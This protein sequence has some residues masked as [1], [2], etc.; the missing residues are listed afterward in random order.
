SVGISMA[1][2]SDI[3]GALALGGEALS[4]GPGD[5]LR[6]TLRTWTCACRDWTRGVE[7]ET[8]RAGGGTEEEDTGVRAPRGPSSDA[9]LL[10]PESCP[11]ESDGSRGTL[12]LGGEGAGVGSTACRRGFGTETS[13]RSCSPAARQRAS[14][15]RSRRR[16]LSQRS[17]WSCRSRHWSRCSA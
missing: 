13:W 7:P 14:H 5:A 6:G 8:R 4:C 15:E 17:R 16:D 12:A 11:A 10:R 3:G 9:V 1:A 2:P